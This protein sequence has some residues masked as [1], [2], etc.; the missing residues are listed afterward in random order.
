LAYAINDSGQVVGE[1]DFAGPNVRHAFRTTATGLISDPGTD[2]GTLGG[3][4]STGRDINSLGVLVGSSQTASGDYHAFYYD[5]FMLD[6]NTVVVNPVAGRVLTYAHGIN[7]AGLIVGEMNLNYPFGPT[8]AFLLVPT[9]PEPS[10]CVLI[11]IATVGGALR[12]YR[13]RRKVCI[14]T[15]KS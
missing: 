11:G 15:E 3:L 4:N 14:T 2:L 13:R 9:V 1:C 12:L 10:S 8:H 7:D 5:N 6:L